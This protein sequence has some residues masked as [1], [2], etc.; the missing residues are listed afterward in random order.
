MT[1]STTPGALEQIVLLALAGFSD[2]VR[3]RDVY[4]SLVA[5]T[6]HEASVAAIHITLTR[7]QDKGWAVC[8]TAD[9]D[10]GEGGKPRRWY[11]LSPDGAEVL[12]DLRRQMDRL[13]EGAAGHP[14]LRG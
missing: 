1:R 2:E 11:R 7:L 13:W 14:L 8:R 12:A 5:A 10:P 9:P 4:E 6:G 3:S